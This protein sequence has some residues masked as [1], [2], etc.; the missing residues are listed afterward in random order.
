VVDED[1]VPV[2]K[3]VVLIRNKWNG[4][5][6]YFGSL[7]KTVTDKNG[8]FELWCSTDREKVISD[9][10]WLYIEKGNYGSEKYYGFLEKD[11][12][13]AMVLHEGKK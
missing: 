9:N 4:D 10:P 2:E 7:G 6:N 12:M 11:D 5:W 3:A 1:K 13:G 8:E